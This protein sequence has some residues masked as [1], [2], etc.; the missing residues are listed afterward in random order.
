MK[1]ANLPESYKKKHEEESGLK[2][3]NIAL[4][5]QVLG[6]ESTTSS[7]CKAIPGKAVAVGLFPGMVLGAAVMFA[8]TRL[9]EMRTRRRSIKSF[10]PRSFPDQ[11]QMDD[12]I[13]EKSVPLP[14]HPWRLELNPP[15]SAGFS[16][17]LGPV[18]EPA[19]DRSKLGMRGDGECD[20][21][22]RSRASSIQRGDVG[23]WDNA[24]HRGRPENRGPP[25][26]PFVD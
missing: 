11:G 26:N 9:R 15:G 16:P 17:N 12:D 14:D 5:R 10:G 6:E 3:E 2:D 25:Q 4:C 18:I 8:L 1:E 7:N 22:D 21:A 23:V 13:S 19:R 20:S 24:E